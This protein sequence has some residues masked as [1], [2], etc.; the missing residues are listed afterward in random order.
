M[1]NTDNTESKNTKNTKSHK[2]T[3]TLELPRHATSRNILYSAE[4]LAMTDRGHKY[5]LLRGRAIS[6]ISA[7]PATP[8]MIPRAQRD[9]VHIKTGKPPRTAFAYKTQLLI[10]TIPQIKM[11][12]L[13][14]LTVD[15]VVEQM[16]NLSINDPRILDAPPSIYRH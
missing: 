11:T 10:I 14:S 16:I 8:L 5:P 12:K 6:Q 1:V 2:I 3:V 4:H 7:V 13:N 15:Q 9:A